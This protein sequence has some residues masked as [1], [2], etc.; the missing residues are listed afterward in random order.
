[1]RVPTFLLRRFD[2]TDRIPWWAAR[3]WRRMHFCNEMD[4]LLVE[5]CKDDYYCDCGEWPKRWVEEREKAS[6]GPVEF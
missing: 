6:A 2:A 5:G 1:M 4:G 3:L